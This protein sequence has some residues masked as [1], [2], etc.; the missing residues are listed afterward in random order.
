MVA[1]QLANDPWRAFSL[2]EMLFIY[3]WKKISKTV[4]EEILTYTY[5]LFIHFGC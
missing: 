1:E 3:I 5:F 4:D 2:Y